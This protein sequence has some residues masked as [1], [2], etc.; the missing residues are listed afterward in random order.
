M[1][2]EDYEWEN[3][4]VDDSAFE[5]IRELTASEI[6]NALLDFGISSDIVG[7]VI[8]ELGYGI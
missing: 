3:G 1:N 8:E 2:R 4:L 5:E 6:S 7:R